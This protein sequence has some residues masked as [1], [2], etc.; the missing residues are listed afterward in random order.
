L[1]L[2]HD[3]PGGGGLLRVGGARCSAIRTESAAA[4]RGTAHTQ[5]E[6]R[7]S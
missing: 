2:A 3:C 1:F 7:R 4:S 6:T 5:S